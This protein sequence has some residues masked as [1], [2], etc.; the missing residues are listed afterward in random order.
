MYYL[1]ISELASKCQLKRFQIMEYYR[2]I[3]ANRQFA[4]EVRIAIEDTIKGL[5]NDLAK[6]E[7]K[8][9]KLIK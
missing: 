4:I 7:E 9:K 2:L 6:L 3:G 1:K 5:E 8:L